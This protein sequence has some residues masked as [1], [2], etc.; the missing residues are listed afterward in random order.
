MDTSVFWMQPKEPYMLRQADPR[1]V[2]W[3]LMIGAMLLYIAFA[4]PYALPRSIPRS[5]QVEHL[6]A[7]RFYSPSV[8]KV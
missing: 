2:V 6:Y 1:R 7:P 4:L 3:D 5:M 8:S